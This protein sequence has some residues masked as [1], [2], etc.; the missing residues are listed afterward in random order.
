V[1]AVPEEQTA[2]ALARVPTGP[3]PSMAQEALNHYNK[4]LDYLKQGNWSKYGEELS[5]LKQILE[6]MT[7]KK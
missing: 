6:N 5:Q 4:A 1:A 7:E 2:K 3:L